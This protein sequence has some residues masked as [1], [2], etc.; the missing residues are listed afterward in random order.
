MPVDI[1]RVMDESNNSLNILCIKNM[2]DILTDKEDIRRLTAGS[3]SQDMYCCK[4]G[5]TVKL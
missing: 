5:L 1:T 4:S 2:L 3:G